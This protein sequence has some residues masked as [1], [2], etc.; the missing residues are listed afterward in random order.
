MA[1]LQTLCVIGLLVVGY[2]GM[3][4]LASLF[5]TSRARVAALVVYA[6]VP[7]PGESLMIATAL[8]AAATGKISIAWVVLAAAVG[9]IMGDNLGFAIG[10]LAF[11]SITL[12]SSGGSIFD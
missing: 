10:R 5:P 9:A 4:R 11:T 8:Y 2:L 12:R 7:L 3:W 1:L 6:A